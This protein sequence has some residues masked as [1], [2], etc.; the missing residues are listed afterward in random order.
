MSKRTVISQAE[1]R[2][3][4]KE[5]KQLR[6][7]LTNQEVKMKFI[8]HRSPCVAKVSAAGHDY[9]RGAIN[10]MKIHGYVTIVTVNDGTLEFYGFKPEQP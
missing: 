5:N 10:A 7:V 2:R 9:L 8:Q 3:I 6:E 1:A 4:L